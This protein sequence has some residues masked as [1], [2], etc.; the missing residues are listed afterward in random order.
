MAVL[1]DD[2]DAATS[3][4]ALLSRAGLCALAYTS[5]TALLQACEARQFDAFV[6]DWML[7]DG[8]AAGLI[9]ALRERRQSVEAPIFVLSGSLAIGRSPADPELARMIISH[10]LRY[11]VKPFRP[12]RLAQE[13]RQALGSPAA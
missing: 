12:S 6:L 5:G 2:T 8:T 9:R 11:R 13:I 3:V 10:R 1:D 7:A 4:A